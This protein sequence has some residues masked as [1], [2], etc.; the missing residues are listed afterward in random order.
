MIGIPCDANGHAIPLG[1]RPVPRTL[2]DSGPNDWTPFNSRTEFET[3]DFLYRRN[4]MSEG[5]INFLAKLWGATLAPH[6]A[7][8]PFKNHKSLYE[9]IDSTPLGEAAWESFSV[10]HNGDIPTDGPVPH[11]MTAEHTAWFR[12]PRKLIHNIIDNTDFKD[13]FDCAPF[14]EYD[15]DKNRRFQDLMSADWAWR[16]AVCVSS[17]FLDINKLMIYEG[18]D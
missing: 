11:W 7:D 15:D 17:M 4:Q 5:N 10:L 6:G 14:Q 2:E 8:P 12:D 1:S 3:A 16:Q 9:A 13:E 18:H